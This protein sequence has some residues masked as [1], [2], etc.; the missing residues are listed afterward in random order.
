GHK[1]FDVLEHDD[2]G[3]YRG[4]VADGDPGEATDFL[5]H[6]RATLGLAEML[7]VRA[8]PRQVNWAAVRDYARVYFP[9]GFAVMAGVGVVDVVH[10]HGFGIVVDGDVHRPAEPQF[11]AGGGP[12][13]PGEVVDDQAVEVHSGLRVDAV[14]VVHVCCVRA[15]AAGEAAELFRRFDS[16]GHGSALLISLDLVAGCRQ[17]R[18]ERIKIG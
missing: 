8:E 7:A 18:P 10:R 9:D 2:L 15:A 6:R 17:A 1:L 3:P 16:L 4:C 13:A 11:N 5:A 14:K 12:A